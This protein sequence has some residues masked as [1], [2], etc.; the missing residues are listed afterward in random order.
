[1]QKSDKQGLTL[2]NITLL[3]IPSL[4]WAS[5]AIVGRLVHTWIAPITLNF[6]RWLV[7]FIV[8]LFFAREVFR[9]GSSLWT[10]WRRYSMLG[11]LGI[12]VYNALQYMA[13][14]TSTPINV[15]LV[16]ASLPF[17]MLLI[18]RVFYRS[19]VSPRQ[20][21]G[22]L[23]SLSGV[24]I[25]LTQGDWRQLFTLHFVPGDIY[26]ILATIAWAVYSWML[27]TRAH[28]AD[29]LSHWSFAIFAQIFYGV[30]WSALFAAGEWQWGDWQVQWSWPLLAAIVYVGVGPAL[31]AFRCWGLAVQRV[32]AA[33]AGFFI[34]L[35]PV[36]AAI[37]SVLI[38]GESPRLYHGL[39]FILVVAGIV[40]SS[41]RRSTTS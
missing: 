18:G 14:Q 21:W 16:N 11:L 3:V 10:Q 8:L 41:G 9:H 40:V 2:A 23:F 6:F 27:S 1:M 37:L 39:A 20:L 26:M 28:P 7:A 35:L 30:W 24:L 22:G 34:N 19:V 38:L 33:T 5:N 31:V 36:F 13:L 15:T 29:L 32:G 25:V 4:L 17:W 12:G